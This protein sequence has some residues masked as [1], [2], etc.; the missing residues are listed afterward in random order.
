[1]FHRVAATSL[2]VV[3]IMGSLSGCAG[4]LQ[5]R[6]S[7]ELPY[8]DYKKLGAVIDASRAYPMAFY[9]DPTQKPLEIEVAY[10]LPASKVLA[11]QW[12]THLAARMNQ[13]LHEVGLYDRR[14]A[15]FAHRVFENRLSSGYH[16]YTFEGDER[17]I[18]DVELS[19][20][21]L[22]KLRVKSFVSATAGSEQVARLTVEVTSAG[23]QRL[24]Q[25]DSNGAKWDR[26]CFDGIA[27][28]ILSDSAFW[29]VISQSP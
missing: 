24:Y 1:M 25:A 7:A 22:V 5:P 18:Q 4:T 28:K 21:R 15:A 10:G 29:K 2:A 20:A 17:L 19:G 26:A 27:R 23:L 9:A 16:I 3:M 12:L 11:S 6:T 14:F 13:A 8:K